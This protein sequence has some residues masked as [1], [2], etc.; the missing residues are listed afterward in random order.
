[1]ANPLPLASGTTVAQSR[2]LIVAQA[3]RMSLLTGGAA[4]SKTGGAPSTSGG[5][6]LPIEKSSATVRVLKP[7][8][9]DARSVLVTAPAG[10]LTRI[11]FAPPANWISPMSSVRGIAPATSSNV[12]PS[13]LIGA[14]SANIEPDVSTTNRSLAL[15]ETPD[16]FDNAPPPATA[17]VPPST[18]VW[19]LYVLSPVRATVPSP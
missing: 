15:T 14:P 4:M 2:W 8:N 10:T 19:P 13:R 16:V 3:P 9:P 5:L 7:V 11:E 6:P 18:T 12:P 17:S 1:M